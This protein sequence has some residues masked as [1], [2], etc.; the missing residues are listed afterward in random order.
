MCISITTNTQ[1]TEILW[2]SQ[3][4]LEFILTQWKV[5]EHQL[6]AQLR[7][8]L[9]CEKLGKNLMSRQC[10]L[11]L[12]FCTEATETPIQSNAVNNFSHQ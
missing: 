3:P 11:T 7:E 6:P 8:Y 2:I 1:L 4:T 10:N 9:H 12:C 5:V